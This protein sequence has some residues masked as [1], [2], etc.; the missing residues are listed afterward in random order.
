M[1]ENIVAFVIFFLVITGA[2]WIDEHPPTLEFQPGCFLIGLGFAVL[3]AG[4]IAFGR[5]FGLGI[6]PGVVLGVISAIAYPF[7]K[8]GFRRL[9][10]R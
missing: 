5:N 4:A 2:R 1:P 7:V 8:K 10:H 6:W 3:I 9:S